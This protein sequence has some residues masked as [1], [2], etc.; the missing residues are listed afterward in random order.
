ML[1]PTSHLSPDRSTRALAEKAQCA[2]ASLG[3]KKWAK[4]RATKER[5]ALPQCRGHGAGESRPFLPAA[6][7]DRSGGI[8]MMHRRESMLFRRTD[9]E[10]L[11]EKK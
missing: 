10:E 2:V 6:R 4:Q 3:H 7:T 11:L 9:S 5:F 8:F 1:T